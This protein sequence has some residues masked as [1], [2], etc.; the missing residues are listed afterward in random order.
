MDLHYR[1]VLGVE[2]TKARS[3][4]FLYLHT[5]EGC[6]VGSLS[7]TWEDVITISKTVYVNGLS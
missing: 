7:S 6:L 2:V 3:R 4:G 5:R 1:H